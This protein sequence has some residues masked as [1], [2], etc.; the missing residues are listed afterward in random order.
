[1]G[2]YIM[3]AFTT[4][5]G[6]EVY[7]RS[8]GLMAM[9]A[10]TGGEIKGNI[11]NPDGRA[12]TFLGKLGFDRQLSPDLR[13]RLTGSAYTTE[14]SHEQDAVRRR[15]GGLALLRGAGEHAVGGRG[16][17]SSPRG[18]IKPGLPQ[19]SSPRSR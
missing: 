17:C 6:A 12:P 3:D 4:E 7:V 18:C 9:G 8:N 11:L 5:V 14:K 16:R 15:P 2:N 1:V 10:I 19:R 13:V